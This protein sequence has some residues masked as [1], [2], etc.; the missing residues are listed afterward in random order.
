MFSEAYETPLEAV[1][2]KN[3]VNP[4]GV[5]GFFKLDITIANPFLRI[6]APSLGLFVRV[7]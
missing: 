3:I 7:F 4:F 5:R 6:I 1:G 2:P